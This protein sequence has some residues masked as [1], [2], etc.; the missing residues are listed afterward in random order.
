[1]ALGGFGF[2]AKRFREFGDVQSKLPQR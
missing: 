2:V 1:V